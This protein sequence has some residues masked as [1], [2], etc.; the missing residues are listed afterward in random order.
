[1]SETDLTVLAWGLATAADGDSQAQAHAI[2]TGKPLYQRH[3]RW[4]GRDGERQTMCWAHGLRDH[5]DYP[6]RVALLVQ[7][8]WAACRDEQIQRGRLPP[9]GEL[10]LA[11]PLS[12]GFSPDLRDAFTQAAERLKFDGMTA[13]HTVFGEH[14]VGLA[15]LERAAQMMQRE[16]AD[17]IYV[18][19]ADTLVAPMILDL[20]A[21]EGNLR[22]RYAPFSRV[23]SE[24]AVC[25]LVAP[26]ARRP[27][28]DGA[29]LVGYASR[30]DD[31]V[32]AD[33]AGLRIGQ[34]LSDSANESLN[35]ADACGRI[36]SDASGG[37]WRA[38]ELQ[39]VLG[40]LSGKTGALP[41]LTAA[42]A[43]GDVGAA[44]ALLSVA[45]AIAAA[46]V[47]SLVLSSERSGC[48]R[49]IVVIPPDAAQVHTDIL[50][51]P[52]NDNPQPGLMRRE[53]FETSKPP[54]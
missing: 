7:R 34:A 42:Q 4:V 20:M 13:V 24:A 5:V 14:A 26:I 18:A 39:I 3:P 33:E 53:R 31:F 41:L 21:V 29:R 25:M 1:M 51:P 28:A 23:P 17:F 40:E 46:D 49:S 22:D 43:I 11:L 16:N 44:T 32:F 27:P 19:A 30:I 6:S 35:A 2:L 9:A 37:R 50:V 10:I 47:P 52:A 54:L 36:V 45:L 15:A 8:A 48:R 38:E 12:L